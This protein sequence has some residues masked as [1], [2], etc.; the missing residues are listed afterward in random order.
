MSN[1]RQNKKF[2]SFMTFYKSRIC[3]YFYMIEIWI[4]F[5]TRRCQIMFIQKFYD[6]LQEQDLQ[7]FLYDRTWDTVLYSTMP[8][9]VA[10]GFFNHNNFAEHKEQLWEY[11]HDKYVT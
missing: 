8:N 2:K 3:N 10:Q 5:F 7:L 6:F 11:N 4:P 1:T 9:H